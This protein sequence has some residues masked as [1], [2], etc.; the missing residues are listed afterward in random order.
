[1]NNVLTGDIMNQGIVPAFLSC[2]F[3]LIVMAGPSPVRA[4]TLPLAC[5]VSAGE[6]DPTSRN[7]ELSSFDGVPEDCLKTMFMHCSAASEKN[8][9]GMGTVMVCSIA[10]EALLKRVFR[11]DFETLLA[12]WQSQ[13]GNESHG[14]VSAHERTEPPLQRVR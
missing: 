13:R 1:M 12:W 7:L 10:Y 9:L 6:A 4:D 11:G 5:R 14:T 8:V 3:M 2:L